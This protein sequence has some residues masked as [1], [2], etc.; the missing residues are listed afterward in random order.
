MRTGAKVT[1]R[2]V[3]R[4][5]A[6]MPLLCSAAAFALVMAN[7]LARVPP[8]PDE[9]ASAHLFQLLILIQLPLIGLFAASADWHR[10]S[11]VVAVLA[12][13]ALAIAVA[14]LPVWLAGY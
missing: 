1:S 7:I 8:Q 11:R 2:Q 14:L 13:Q 5:F 10:R 6:A 9:N 4:A 12:L 3:N